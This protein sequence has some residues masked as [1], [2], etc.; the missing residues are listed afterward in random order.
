MRSSIPCLSIISAALI[1]LTSGLPFSQLS[2]ESEIIPG[3][4]ALPLT[5]RSTAVDLTS[6]PTDRGRL[7]LGRLAKAKGKYLPAADDDNIS[8]RGTSVGSAQLGDTPDDT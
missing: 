3:S 7:L 4:Y 1:S 6:S 2:S 8:K 5:R